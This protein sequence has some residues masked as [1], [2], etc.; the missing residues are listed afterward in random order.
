MFFGFIYF[1]LFI[2]GSV[3]YFI[4]FSLKNSQQSN[5]THWTMYGHVPNECLDWNS[6]E[7]TN[8]WAIVFKYILMRFWGSSCSQNTIMDDNTPV[9][10]ESFFSTVIFRFPNTAKL[11]KPRLLYMYVGYPTCRAV[12]WEIHPLYLIQVFAKLERNFSAIKTMRW[13]STFRDAN[14]I[15]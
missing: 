6:H 1:N 15:P 10:L 11:A 8:Y 2:I 3:K 14:W 7:R 5:I 9:V 4:M 13:N 12:E